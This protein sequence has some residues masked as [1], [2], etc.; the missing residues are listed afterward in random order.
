MDKNSMHL[1]VME[2]ERVLLERRVDKIIAE[3]ADGSFCLKP[4]HID[5]VSALRMG[6]LLYQSDGV[7]HY[8][9]VD[10]GVLVKYGKRVLVSA[11]NSIEGTDL[12]ELEQ[13]VREQFH[14]T[15]A[16]KKATDVALKSLEADLLLHFM[17]L[18]RHS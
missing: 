2:P 17:E 9:A 5:F 10:E 3:G 13:A 7:E 18:D 11:L 6:I 16:I 15:E 12:A 4:R 14:K 1:K 8:I